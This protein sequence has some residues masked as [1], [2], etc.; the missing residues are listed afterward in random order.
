MRSSF[1]SLLSLAIVALV[2]TVAARA[3]T[4]DVGHSCAVTCPD[5]CIAIYWF[6]TGKCTVAC[7]DRARSVA[8]QY[9]S[10]QSKKDSVS[11]CIKGLTKGNSKKDKDCK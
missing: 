4:C 5:G 6:D 8:K 1:L 11:I 7:A 2:A 10:L 3:E 9:Q